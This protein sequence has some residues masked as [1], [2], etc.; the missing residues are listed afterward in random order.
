MPTR[1]PLGAGLRLGLWGRPF[2]FAFRLTA[3]PRVAG[4]ALPDSP[5]RQAWGAISLI[6]QISA[7]YHLSSN[8]QIPTP[9]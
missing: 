9:A 5:C 1:P 4:P 3:L 7:L 2:P 8:Q 6:E